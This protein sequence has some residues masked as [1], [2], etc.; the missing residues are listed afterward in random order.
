LSLKYESKKKSLLLETHDSPLLYTL[1][2][3]VDH[4]GINI[5]DR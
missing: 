4:P 5:A 1:M 2:R 3:S